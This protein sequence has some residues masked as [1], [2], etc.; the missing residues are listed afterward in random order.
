MNF[1]ALLTLFMAVPTSAQNL[2]RLDQPELATVL[3]LQEELALTAPRSDQ[4]YLVRIFSVP[5][6]VYECGGTVE[7]CPDV[8]LF[9]T[10]SFGDLGET[11]ALFEIPPQ[12]GWEFGGWATPSGNGEDRMASFVLRTAVPDSNI[13]LESRR[14]WRPV[15]Y[16]VHVSPRSA[17]YV[18]R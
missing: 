16:V 12:K 5:V 3:G 13:D 18:Q 14:A 10:V 7:S 2:Q 1:L 6:G 9:V 17:S 15:E 11:P 4:P 8:R